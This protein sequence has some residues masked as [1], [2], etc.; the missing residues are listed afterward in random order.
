MKRYA[1]TLLLA[2]ALIGSSMAAFAANVRTDYDHS[3]N[4]SQYNTYSWGKVH[5]S[6][7]FFASRIQGA[8]DQQ[9][10]AKGWK[11]VPSGGA[12]TVFATDNIHNQQEVQTMY[13]GWGG[14][15][16]YGWGWR[17]WGWS[18]G[19]ADP[20]F[21]TSTTTTTDKP[22]SNLVIDLFEGSSKKLLWRGLA[23][24]DLSS[25]A[26]KNTKNVDGDIKDMFRSF[27]PKAEK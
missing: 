17:H 11:L 7:P 24:E 4:F 22:I 9:L 19:W 1:Q 14:G 23:T 2:I 21:G 26:D 27:P 12:V 8:V 18:G 5:T 15:W 16:G 13:D 25:N 20:G 3:V 10:Q 6:N